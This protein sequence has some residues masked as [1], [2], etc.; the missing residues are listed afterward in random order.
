MNTPLVNALGGY[1]FH[2]RPSNVSF[3]ATYHAYMVL[4]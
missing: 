2:V 3:S 4:M 1:Q